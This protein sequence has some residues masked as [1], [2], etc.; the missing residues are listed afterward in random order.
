MIT[1][2]IV[3]SEA[4]VR[5][6]RDSGSPVHIATDNPMLA[7]SASKESPVENIDALVTQDDALRLGAIALEISH[8]IDRR[9]RTPD[10]AAQYGLLQ[11]T[12]YTAGA[13]SR[14]VA[15]LL[16]RGAALAR[17]IERVRPGKIALYLIDAPAREPAEPFMRPRFSHPARSFAE[18]GFF[19]ALSAVFEPVAADLPATINDTATRDFIRRIALFS[20][21][22]IAYEFLRRFPFLP[23]GGAKIVVAEENESI[24][25]TLPWILARGEA[26]RAGGSLLTRVMPDAG[27][28]ALQRFPEEPMISAVLAAPVRAGIAQTGVFRQEQA[29]A[30]AGIILAQV[31]AGLAHLGAQVR[32]VDERLS[33]WFGK[34][35]GVILT[36]G[37]YGAAGAQAY[38]LC[39]RRGI[40]VVEFEHGVTAGISALT[41]TKLSE[42]DI[43]G[44]DL[45][46]VCAERSARAFA[47]GQQ[48]AMRAI[49]IGLPD[50]VRRIQRRP[51]QRF[52]ARR[53]LALSRDDFGIMH[54]S[55]LPYYGNHRAGLGTPSETT[56]F[57]IDR[58][59]IEKVYAN[60]RH[61]VI[62]KQYPTQ[63]FPFEPGYEKL[64]SIAPNVRVTKREDFRYIRA[65][66]DV[67]VTMTPTSTLGWCVGA[68]KPLVWLDSKIINPLS[69]AALR[70]AFRAS[71][72]FVDL[73]RE[74]WPAQLRAL[75][76]RDPAAI[77]ADWERRRSPR[78]SLL[79]EFM[80]GPDGSPGRRAAGLVLDTLHGT[81]RGAP[82]GAEGRANI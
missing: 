47:S 23:A 35:G 74:D 43:P 5:R 81:P 7:F 73:D 79:R 72:L 53:A 29:E 45:T 30:I 51:L 11:D 78:E 25:E 21:P 27:T 60:L 26:V 80:I 28:A 16:H 76:D 58:D 64:F 49:A 8:E 15:S 56:T 20:S 37:L 14:M 13:V 63:R 48:K 3:D 61:K 4:A 59:S 19:G 65:A 62:F 24:R 31:A 52:L 17:S 18:Y 55:T 42:G 36:N 70:D 68:G 82:V 77:L 44:G 22:V 12:I 66:A 57:N 39:R 67:I 2:A 46:L 10:I 40:K 1:L 34:S 75:L 6:A 54:V 71:F 41:D 32:M 9:L 69:S 50:C 38:G 33:A